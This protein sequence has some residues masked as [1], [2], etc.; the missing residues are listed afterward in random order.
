MQGEDNTESLVVIRLVK[1]IRQPVERGNQQVGEPGPADP[2]VHASGNPAGSLVVTVVDADKPVVLHQQVPRCPEDQHDQKMVDEGDRQTTLD[3]ENDGPH[4]QRQWNHW[5][6]QQGPLES[7]HQS[8]VPVDPDESGE[9]VG[10]VVDRN[11]EQDAA[12]ACLLEEKN[13]KQHPQHGGPD[14][15]QPVL[16]RTQDPVLSNGQIVLSGSCG[17]H[18]SIIDRRTDQIVRR[19]TF[20]ATPRLEHGNHSPLTPRYFFFST[21]R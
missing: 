12:Q 14:D 8:P 5:P 2:E 1:N 21:T 19:M 18:I 20:S 7:L 3:H 17:G 10:N 16:G 6:E 9:M 13:R 15:Q 4:C 11:G